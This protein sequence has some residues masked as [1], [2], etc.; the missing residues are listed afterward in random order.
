VRSA[1]RPSRGRS[2]GPQLPGAVDLGHSTRSVALQTLPEGLVVEVTELDLLG[3]I[4]RPPPTL[5]LRR[6]GGEEAFEEGLDIGRMS[7][8][9]LS[10]LGP[11]RVVVADVLTGMGL[12]RVQ[13]HPPGLGM[14]LGH[15]IEQRTLRRAERSRERAELHDQPP[16]PP[17]LR[18][19]HRRLVVEPGDLDAHTALPHRHHMAER[20]KRDLIT[21]TR[22]VLIEM[23]V[24]V[25]GAVHAS[26][27]RSGGPRGEQRRQHGTEYQ[28]HGELERLV[29]GLQEGGELRDEPGKHLEVD[30]IDEATVD[31]P[32][33]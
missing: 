15:S 30:G 13:K 29:G 26:P 21:T 22:D 17:Q 2:A 9:G 5:L 23:R 1:R 27:C 16:G 24:V 32:G 7:P 25:A 18:Q 31:Q 12:A 20:L 33:P 28:V 6:A 10:E 4:H 11:E 3:L 8:V 19:P 14:A